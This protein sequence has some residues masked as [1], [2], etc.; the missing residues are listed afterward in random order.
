MGYWGRDPIMKA[1][2]L[3]RHKKGQK[4]ALLE[5]AKH[6]KLVKYQQN[7]ERMRR[8]ECE[9]AKYFPSS[10]ALLAR[11]FIDVLNVSVVSVYFR[12]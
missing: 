1:L 8:F 2:L 4:E 9:N 11:I 10:L 6:L 12:L 5:G 7:V 3:Y